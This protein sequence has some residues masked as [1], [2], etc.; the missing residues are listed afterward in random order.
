MAVLVAA[1][2]V[3]RRALTISQVGVGGLFEEGDG[4]VMGEMTLS[5]ECQGC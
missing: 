4:G 1:A 5:K 3:R 2:T